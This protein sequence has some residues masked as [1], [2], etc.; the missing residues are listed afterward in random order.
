M[1]YLGACPNIDGPQHYIYL[2]LHCVKLHCVKLHLKLHSVPKPTLEPAPI[3]MGPSTVT[4]APSSTPWPMRGWRTAPAAQHSTAQH[5]NDECQCTASTRSRQCM[6]NS[7]R[8]TASIGEMSRFLVGQ[9]CPTR[10]RR[11]K[12]SGTHQEHHVCSRHP[13]LVVPQPP[14]APLCNKHPPPHYLSIPTSQQLTSGCQLTLGRAAATQ[15]PRVRHG[16]MHIAPHPHPHM[17]A[18]TCV[19]THTHGKAHAHVCANTTHTCS[20]HAPLVVPEPPSATLCSMETLS[21]TTAVSP[22]TMPVA[23]SN[24]MPRPRVAAGCTSTWKIWDT[25]DCGRANKRS[26]G[27]CVRVSIP[28]CVDEVA[29]LLD[30]EKSPTEQHECERLRPPPPTHTHTPTHAHTN[31][32]PYRTRRPKPQHGPTCNA[33]ASCKRPWCHRW[34]MTL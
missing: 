5:G 19:R 21:P 34:F 29:R 30:R 22:M 11:C 28:V 10:A 18:C 6:T 15:G 23:W 20:H 32:H 9:G 25:R 7:N 14:S 1:P 13:P 26:C 33:S 3:S 2:K 17:H 24:M 31:S 12:G 4:P 27:L 16:H 8:S